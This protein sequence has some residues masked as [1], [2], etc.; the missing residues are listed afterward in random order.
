MNDISSIIK[1]P[2]KLMVAGEYAVLDGGSCVVVAVSRYVEARIESSQDYMLSIPKLTEEKINW[3]YK[4]DHGLEFNYDD[5]KFLFLK[6]AMEVTLTYL[7]ERGHEI[8]PFHLHITSDLNDHKSNK[9]YGLGSS[10]AIVVAVTTS[11]LNFFG[12]LEDTKA[13]II[14]KLSAMAH[15]ITQGKGSCADIAACVYGGWLHY[16]AFDGKWLIDNRE[17]NILSMLEKPW[18]N[19]KIEKISPPNNLSL[20][21]GWTN[22]SVGT[23]PMVN[24]IMEFK[25]NSKE[26]YKEFMKESNE[27]TKSLIKAFAEDNLENALQALSKNRGALVKLG[28]NANVNIETMKLKVMCDIA[29]KYGKG[30]SSGAGGGDCGIAF[31]EQSKRLEIIKEWEASEIIPLDLSVATTGYKIIQ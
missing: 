23:V 2:G 7:I 1:V 3:V 18:P 19:L 27:A 8:K 24:K 6:K 16:E 4:K 25:A 11:I 12:E 14:F 15:F 17:E 22:E 28:K 29:D 9:K 26:Q 31:V 20:L 10:A 13:H 5:S 30:K 21:V